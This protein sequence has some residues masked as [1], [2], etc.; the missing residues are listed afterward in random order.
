MMSKSRATST[1]PGLKAQMRA[2]RI[3][4]GRR[5]ALIEPPTKTPE[6]TTVVRGRRFVARTKYVLHPTK[7]W[8]R[9]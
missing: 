1:H 2:F 9:A 4:A 3:L 6:E 7:G 5:P 8:R